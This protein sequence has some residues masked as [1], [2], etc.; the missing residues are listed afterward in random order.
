MQ[1]LEGWT[2][3]MADLTAAAQ[4]LPKWHIIKAKNMKMEDAIS[5]PEALDPKTDG[6]CIP[7]SPRH[8]MLRAKAIAA[9]GDVAADAKRVG[10]L[11]DAVIAQQQQF[12]DGVP[13]V[14]CLFSCFYLHLDQDLGSQ[15]D[16]PEELYLFFR[17]VFAVI[18]CTFDAVAMADLRDSDEEFTL[19]ANDIPGSINTDVLG[20]VEAMKTVLANKPSNDN[21]ALQ[22]IRLR[23]KFQYE[24]LQTFSAMSK[25]IAL[26]TDESH[27][28]QKEKALKHAVGAVKQQVTTANAALKALS[29]NRP[30]E[31]TPATEEKLFSAQAPLWLS[32]TSPQKLR[33]LPAWSVT[34][35]YYRTI[36]DDC[37]TVATWPVLGDSATDILNTV[38]HFGRAKK[39][40]VS[41]SLAMSFLHSGSMEMCMGGMSIGQRILV[42]LQK[43]FGA[44]LYRSVFKGDKAI[45]SELLE[46][47]LE[48]Q[49]KKLNIVNM[50]TPDAEMKEHMMHEFQNMLN[51]WMNEAGRSLL[52]VMHA[53]LTVRGRCH[54]NLMKLVASFRNLADMSY[55]LDTSLFGMLP[56]KASP[57]EVP[58]ELMQFG[59][60]LTKWTEW[61]TADCLENTLLCMS[62][63]NLVSKPEVFLRVFYENYTALSKSESLNT[64]HVNQ[65]VCEKIAENKQ[66]LPISV[67]TRVPSAASDTTLIELEAR[68]N[69]ANGIFM[70]CSALHDGGIVTGLQQSKDALQSISTIWDHRCA[71]VFLNPRPKAIAARDILRQR[72]AFQ[73]DIRLTL[74]KAAETFKGTSAVLQRYQKDE[75]FYFSPFLEASVKTC[76]LNEISL[77][78]LL[79]GLKER[80]TT[81]SDLAAEFDVQLEQPV[82][83]SQYALGVNP[84]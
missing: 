27:N 65:K 12:M 40:L 14:S 11:L 56:P 38:Q 55:S 70:S 58:Q 34:C 67:R 59:L 22:A 83:A 78:L 1:S 9:A 64:L 37:T 48:L 51:N 36:L 39:P 13:L 82:I 35:A 2:D 72:E 25:L 26:N 32:I 76:R 16:C 43:Q 20:I 47:S 31:E 42:T 30:A 18:Q 75:K 8:E 68:R 46:G 71:A 19:Y 80:T 44:P 63:L 57:K 17:S 5:C 74:G 62:E 41:R 10:D 60:V 45:L 23:L 69:I 84:K 66:V 6:M 15:T 77:G 21:K 52:Q 81:L 73:K 28:Q 79:E 50:P 33:P 49:K 7:F 29:K 4:A 3:K 61:L 54:R 53:H 24:L